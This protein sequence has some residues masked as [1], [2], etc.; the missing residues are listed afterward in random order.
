MFLK[1]RHLLQVVATTFA[2]AALSSWA[3]GSPGVVVGGNTRATRI[4]DLGSAATGSRDY[5]LTLG[6]KGNPPNSALA[7]A[8]RVGTPFFEIR[9]DAQQ[10]LAD[11]I[12]IADL[13]GNGSPEIIGI[14]RGIFGKNAS[15]G[16]A[17]VRPVIYVFRAN[18][19]LLYRFELPARTSLNPGAVKVLDGPSAGKKQVVVAANTFTSTVNL[20]AGEF[21]FA[22]CQAAGPTCTPGASLSLYFCDIAGCV[23]GPS[24]AASGTPPNREILTFPAVMI[25]DVEPARAGSEVV[26]LSKS[27]ILVVGQ[28]RSAVTFRQ[29]VQPGAAFTSYDATQDKPLVGQNGCDSVAMSGLAYGGRRYGLYRLVNLD[30]DAALELLIAGDGIN[31]NNGLAGGLY[32]A[33][34]LAGLPG[35]DHIPFKWRTCLQ[36]SAF[37]FTGEVSGLPQG[38]AIGVTARGMTT[39]FNGD[40]VVDVVAT[41]SLGNAVVTLVSG[42]DGSLL[43]PLTADG[44]R[45]RGVVLDVERIGAE[46]GIPDLVLFQPVTKDQPVA[47][48]SIFR[49][50]GPGGLAGT[51]LPDTTS[52]SL[53]SG[54]G[55]LALRETI[56]DFT[57]PADTS[58]STVDGHIGVHTLL[59][60]ATKTLLGYSANDCGGA[61]RGWAVTNGTVQSVLNLARRPGEIV[62]ALTPPGASEGVL[63]IQPETTATT[64]CK[65]GNLQ[66]LRQEGAMLVDN[67]DLAVGAAPPPPP[68]P[69]EPP[70]PPPPPGTGALTATP[71][72]LAFSFTTG[73]PNPLPQLLRIDAGQDPLTFSISDNAPW[74]FVSPGFGST[75]ESVSVGVNPTGLPA[76]TYNAM[77]S[78]SAVGASNSPLT[79]PVTLAVS[80]APPPTPRLNVSAVSISYS[81]TVGQ[82]NPPEQV[83]TVGS[84]EG[85]L[86][87]TVS[88]SAPWLTA[89]PSAGTTSAQVSA[90]VDAS[91][92]AAGNY[93][94]QLTVSA[95]GAS[96]SP[97]T[98]AVF[99]NVNPVGGGLGV[100]PTSLSFTAAQGGE[101]PVAQGLQISGATG[102]Q[103]AATATAT[104]LSVV[105]ASGFVPGTASVAVEITGLAVGTYNGTVTLASLGLSPRQVPVTL[106]V[107]P[108]PLALTLSPRQLVFNV[109]AGFATPV[110]QPLSIAST[111][112][113]LSWTASSDSPWLTLSPA[114]GQTPATATVSVTASQLAPGIYRGSV[115]VSAS[116]VA[117]V[118][119]PVELAVGGVA[120]SLTV[121]P[122]SLVFTTQRGLFPS[123]QSFRVESPF[124][125]GVAFTTF[126]TVPWLQLG[127]GGVTPTTNFANLTDGGVALAPGRYDGVIYVQA[128]DGSGAVAV[129]VSLTVTLTA[130]PTRR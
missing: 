64:A 43:R 87:F 98:V 83:F 92:F 31:I 34:D 28:N 124:G 19:S 52:P 68:P 5:L 89:S 97:V 116:G 130:P 75:G 79:V 56:D 40:G 3:Q 112:A 24:V 20:P 70:P 82:T 12:D 23:A 57:F 50:N 95:P 117:S 53:A 47:R 72:S 66:A 91:G 22:N 67:G 25:G 80:A 113:R 123:T 100:L 88:S 30:S 73:G 101:N 105:P 46:A 29:F 76:G 106:T 104:W 61:L 86:G 111:G 13:D 110:S 7:F 16:L 71:T 10:P 44:K 102:S 121:T 74:L 1:R 14:F 33:Y 37:G 17:L 58:F 65:L 27:R 128:A 8:A 35:G 11:L 60:G 32:E 2:L 78:V 15:G 4:V 39:D 59:S 18:G 69:D 48:H 126:A 122:P 93:N 21:D 96:N 108:P 119:V 77:L 109:P 120:T 62:N 84:S 9:R 99:L 26:I 85:P 90:R 45:L 42:R 103:F 118:R 63:L 107:T 49:F 129:P 41:E 36:K 115:T 125:G 51:I 6:P 94:A 114:S 38:Y 55:V 54:A 81:A 127:G